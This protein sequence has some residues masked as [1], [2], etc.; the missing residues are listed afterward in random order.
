MHGPPQ[1]YTPDWEAAGES[2]RKLASLEPDLVVCG[3]GHAMRGPDMTRALH[4]LADN[5]DA[6]AV[7]EHGRYVGRPAQADE[8]GVTYIPP[9]S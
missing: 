7:P 5:F 1:Y 3:H 2:V 6:I 8:S 9:K 4:A